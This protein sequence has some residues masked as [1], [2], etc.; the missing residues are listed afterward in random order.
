MVAVVVMATEQVERKRSE[1]ELVGARFRREKWVPVGVG[2][3]ERSEGGERAVGVGPVAGVANAM[4]KSPEGDQLESDT[5]SGK[6]AR[7]LNY[8]VRIVAM[9]KLVL[10]KITTR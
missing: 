2:G 7:A 10:V 4:V 9:T 8:L 3:I 1:M 6:R 5:L